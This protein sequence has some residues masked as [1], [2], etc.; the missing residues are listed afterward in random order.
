MGGCG[1]VTQSA[2]GRVMKG[3]KI[4]GGTNLYFRGAG[5]PMPWQCPPPPLKGLGMG[6]HPI[7][8]TPHWQLPPLSRRLV[9]RW[10]PGRGG[11]CAWR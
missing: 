6:R 5:P 2:H 10:G 7:S 3:D 11:H 9:G 8:K 1:T 4:K